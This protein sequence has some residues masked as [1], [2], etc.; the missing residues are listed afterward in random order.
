MNAVFRKNN[1]ERLFR[2]AFHD[3]FVAKR[4]VVLADWVAST[5]TETVEIQGANPQQYQ[6][7]LQEKPDW[8]ERRERCHRPIGR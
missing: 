6:L 1:Y 3:A 5:K 4:C 7:I 8:R 2:D